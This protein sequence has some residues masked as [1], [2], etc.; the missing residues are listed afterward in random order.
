MLLAVDIGN[1]NIVFGLY[2]E[3][4]LVH[5]FRVSTDR[6]RTEDEY[7]VLLR[8]LMSLR[9][10][11]PAVIRGSILASVVPPLT[12]V[13]AQAVRAAFAREP[14]VVG[15]GLK[16]GMPVLYENPHEV[17]AD[18]VVNG[19]AAYERFKT[20][21]IV[22]DLGTATTF[23]CISPNGEYL[24]G[25]IVP[26]VQVA[27]DA[28]FARAAKL[29]PIEIAEPPRVLG[30]N[31]THALQS[32]V[33]FGA[34]A[35]IDGLIERLETD[36]GFPCR[37]IAT[38]GLA[39]VVAKHTTKIQEVDPNLTLEGLRILHERNASSSEARSSDRNKRRSR[40]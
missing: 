15:P 24:G 38:G 37:V 26:G 23:D 1:T 25:V 19:I 22:V 3:A 7:G 17:G 11:E 4:D 9:A 31:T 14:L 39:A 20:G 33:V 5:T 16:T 13:L 12:H 6:S 10:I 29:R 18:R 40:S 36:V 28:L 30:R 27:L 2:R 35:M 32:G 34:A 21:V 8:E